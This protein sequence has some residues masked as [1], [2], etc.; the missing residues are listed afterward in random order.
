MRFN[1]RHNGAYGPLPQKGKKKR[2]VK[3]WPWIVIGATAFAL[4]FVAETDGVSGETVETAYTL[5]RPASAE[6]TTEYIQVISAVTYVFLTTVGAGQTYTIPSDF[7]LT[8]NSVECIGGGGDGSNGS[9]FSAVGAGGGAGAYSKSVDLD[10]SWTVGSSSVSYRVGRGG[11][12]DTWFNDTSFPASGQ[13][14]GARSGS[15]ASGTSGGAGGLASNGYAIGT[16]SVKYDGGT[17]GAGSN[18]DAGGGGGGGGAA[19]PSGAGGNG[20]DFDGT[21]PEGGTANGGGT[22]ADTAGTEFDGTHGAGGGGSDGGT[23]PGDNGALY[24]GGGGGG[25]SVSTAK[26]EGA[27]GLIVI[28]Y[29]PTVVPLTAPHFTSTN[30]VHTITVS[31]TYD[32]TPALVTDGDTWYTH[33]VED[34]YA[35]FATADDTDGNWVKDDDSNTDLYSAIDESP[36]GSD[37]DYIQSG[38]FPVNDITKIKLNTSPDFELNEPV[39]ISY[40]YQGTHAAHEEMELKVRLVENTTTRKEWIHSDIASSWTSVQ[41]VELSGAE[42]A[43]ITNWADLYLEFEAHY[44]TG[45]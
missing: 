13:K 14:C 28:T 26:G 35:L 18:T 4:H 9:T 21:S 31:G 30:T 17:G 39:R 29:P 25:G 11:I 15:H 40:R 7:D 6:D 42:Y 12:D 33:K 19:G 45:D 34:T 32:L 22:A 16:G 43:S 23:G 1:G 36:P 10:D 38:T 20:Q 8:D 3:T 41:H 37:T 27:D 2:R 5:S 24:G 44:T